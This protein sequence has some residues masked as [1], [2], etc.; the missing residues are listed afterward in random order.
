MPHLCC[1]SLLNSKALQQKGTEGGNE[2]KN[3]GTT[4]IQETIRPRL[5]PGAGRE[6]G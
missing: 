6:E 5:L 2:N 3:C 4:C 1:Y